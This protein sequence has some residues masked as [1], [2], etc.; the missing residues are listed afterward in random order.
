M[1]RWFEDISRNDVPI[2]GGKTASLGEMIRNLAS[3]GIRV[4][5][6]FAITANAYRRFLAHNALE[7]LMAAQ[8]ARL[9]AGAP[10]ADV[11]QTIRTA[12]AG[13]AL[14]DTLAQEIRAAYAELNKRG[15]LDAAPVAVRSSATAEDLPDASFAGQQETFLNVIGADAL[16]DAVRRCFASL[17]TDRAITYRALHGYPHLKVA[18]SVAV[19]RMVRSDRGAAG[20]AFTLDTETGFRNLV[21]INGAFGLGENV[22]KGTVTPD[23]WRVF[24]PLLSDATVAPILDRTIGSKLLKMVLDA[25]GTPTNIDTTDAERASA[26]LDNE[27]VLALVYHDR[28]ALRHA[29]G[30]RVGRRW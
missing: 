6:G 3:A 8:L 1:L 11:G 13:G 26:V 25:H 30:Y 17:Y 21:V 16:L 24:K 29:D 28:S 9:D 10:L 19:Q 7:P 20:V 14:P 27:Q 2:V 15:G 18:L 23:E 4:P 5:G 12:I 22:V